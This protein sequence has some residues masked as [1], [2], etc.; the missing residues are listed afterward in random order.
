MDVI[1]AISFIFDPKISPNVISTLAVYV[2]NTTLISS[3]LVVMTTIIK[4]V[5]NSLIPVTLQNFTIM[6]VVNMF[7]L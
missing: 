5:A 4:P 7:F 2:K 1:N 6:S 3:I